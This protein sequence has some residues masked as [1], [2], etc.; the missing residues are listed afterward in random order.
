MNSV[1]NEDHVVASTTP[2]PS[3]DGLTIAETVQLMLGREPGR[4]VADQIVPVAGA[5]I[6]LAVLGRITSVEKKG[7]FVDPIKRLLTVSDPSSTGNSILDAALTGIIAYGK[8]PQ[9][10]RAILSL[11]KPVLSEVHRAL[12]QRGLVR[13]TGGPRLSSVNLEIADA[14]RVEHHRTVMRRAQSLPGSVTDPRVG[15][16]IDLLRNGGDLYRGYRGPTEDHDN[17]WYPGHARE[18]VDAILR[19]EE[20]LTLSGS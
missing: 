20:F 15:A 11:S 18:T 6:E 8:P 19:A 7:F 1:G 9:I 14:E 17:H 4:L 16:V 5:L 2:E 13:V 12:E 3:P 10:D